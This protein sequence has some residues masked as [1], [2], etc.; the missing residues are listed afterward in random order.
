[1]LFIDAPFAGSWTRLGKS[2]TLL[3]G[4]LAV[5]ATAPP[6]ERG[7][8]GMR[9]LIDATDGFTTAARVLLGLFLL[10]TGV[11]H[12]LHTPFVASLIPAWS[13]GDAVSWTYVAG[14]ALVVFGAGLLVP[15]TAPGA[16]LLAGCMVFS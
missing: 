3:G 16:A 12:F 15:V 11:Q 1:V 2:W 5:A 6:I 10:L 7:N 8:A 4:A 13:P 9:R 14:V